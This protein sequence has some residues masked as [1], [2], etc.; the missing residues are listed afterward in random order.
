LIDLEEHSQMPGLT[1]IGE[2]Q[3]SAGVH[4]FPNPARNQVQFEL[5]LQNAATAS[6]YLYDLKGQLVDQVLHQVQLPA[7]V[8]QIP[9]NVNH[10]TAGVYVYSVNVGG[11]MSSGKLL[12]D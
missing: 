2:L 8:Q 7:G 5:T 10:M 1:N 11:E 6:I 12:V 3:S 9:F 4:V